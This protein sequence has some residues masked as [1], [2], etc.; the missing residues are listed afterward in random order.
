MEKPGRI[1]KM[2][3]GLPFD[4]ITAMAVAPD[5]A[6]WFGAISSVSRIGWKNLDSLYNSEWLAE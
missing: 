5:G 2:E 4:E 1:F 3:N 6:V